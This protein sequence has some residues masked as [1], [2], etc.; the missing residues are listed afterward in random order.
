MSII[1]TLET[2]STSKSINASLKIRSKITDF[3]DSL[4]KSNENLEACKNE[5]SGIATK[6]IVNLGVEK[7]KIL[8]KLDVLK[9][10]EVA[11]TN[12]IEAEISSLDSEIEANNK[13]LDQFKM[14]E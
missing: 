14:F 12:N 6:E 4:R 11:V 2:S 8:N 5:V 3:I 13:F 9:E 10:K 1:S 7:T